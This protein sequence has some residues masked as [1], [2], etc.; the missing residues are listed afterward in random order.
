[1]RNITIDLLKLAMAFM[2][3]GLH[4]N[5]LG[6]FKGIASYIFVNGISRIAV[7]V[8]FVINGYYFHNLITKKS[9][10]YWCR[11]VILLYVIWMIFYSYYWFPRSEFN[12]VGI[13]K[14][15]FIGYFHL[16]YLPAMLGAALLMSIAKKFK[17]SILILM[18][19]LTFIAGVLIQ[20]IGYYHLLDNALLDEIFNI[21]SS[22]RNFIFLS[23]PFFCIGFLI[24]KCSI[25]KN[26]TTKM[27][28]Y[29][30]LFGLVLLI[31]ESIFNFSLSMRVIGIDN[32]FFLIIAAPGIFVLAL[33][34]PIT[35]HNKK[36]SLYSSSIYFL[37]IFVLNVISELF[38]YKESLLTI[39]VIILSMLISYFVIAVN[40]R[41]PYLI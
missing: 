25:D 16:W 41:I 23:F 20:Y 28:F 12:I 10:F 3:V 37:H 21:P 17:T 9:Y 29:F 18:I 11:R 32:L 6:E 2:V 4:T 26:I 39:S 31:I 5:F 34:I 7:P 13:I 22:H 35:S 38:G 14:M 15:L 8:F 24:N 19:S 27:I 30:S 1:M 36:I 40:K 33:K